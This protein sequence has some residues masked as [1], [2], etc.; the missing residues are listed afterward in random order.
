MMT[1]LIGRLFLT[2]L[3]A[4]LTTS[5]MAQSGKIAGKVT[6]QE[7]GDALIG[8]SVLVIGTSL[9]AATDFDGNYNIL[10]VPPGVYTIR[11]SYVGYTNKTISNVRV[12]TGLT[13]R[14]DVPLS[15]EVLTLGEEITITAERPMVQKDQTASTATVSGDQIAAL[16]VTEISQVVSLQ[17]GNVGGHFR[18]GRTGEVAYMIDGVPVTDKYDG[19]AVVDVNKNMVSELQVISGAFNAEYG[20]AMSAIVN[21][22]TKDGTNKIEGSLGTYFGD[23]LTSHDDIFPK[24][25]TY[26]P[27][28]IQNYEGSLSGALIKD[29]L[30]F[31]LVGRY[32]N[33]GG[34]FYGKRKYNADNFLYEDPITLKTVASSPGD[35]EYVQMNN[36]S[37]I[38]G[39]GKF[40]WPIS[41]SLKTSVNLIYEKREWKDYNRYYVYNPDG[42]KTNYQ[43]SYTALASLTHTVSAS[44]FYTVSVSGFSKFFENYVNDGLSKNYVHPSLSNS[45]ASYTFAAGGMDMNQFQRETQS[46]AAK[47]DLWSQVTNEHQIK[48]GADIKFHN[49]DFLSRNILPQVAE[50]TFIPAAGANPYINPR[51][52]DITTNNYDK[53]NRTPLEMAAYIQ[54]K[55]EFTNFILNVGLRF[56][57]FDPAGKSPADPTDP[58]IYTPMKESNRF[59]DS[60]GN[61]KIDPSEQDPINNLK[62]LAEREKYWWKKSKTKYQI[63]PRIGAAFPITDRGKIYFS[64]GHF[65]QFPNFD[66]LYRNANYKITQGSGNVGTVGNADLKPEKNVQMEL[67]LNQQLTDNFAVDATVYFRDFRDLS[68]TRSDEII[69]AIGNSYNQVVNSDFAFIRGFI[70]TLNQR[71]SEGLAVTLDY[72]F[73][74]AKGTASDPDAARNAILGGQQPEVK[75]VSLDWDQTHT[76]NTT[77]NYSQKN[78]GLSTIVTFGSGNPYTP[79]T[80]ADVASLALNSQVRPSTI[81]MDLR[82]YYNIDI[83]TGSLSLYARI[84]NLFDTLNEYGVFNDS[85]RAGYTTDELYARKNGADQNLKGIN[86]LDEYFTNPQ[87][88]SEPRRIEFGVSY[89]F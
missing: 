82:G 69:T 41:T 18:G 25:S 88:Y 83:P 65:Y 14:I 11:V 12:A 87:F 17:A 62:S 37:R 32:V 77:V 75:L 26:N 70:L 79:R 63:S 2:A 29:N 51:Y 85:G 57:W 28:N 34:H 84:Y 54:D 7:N 21:V 86:T 31:F 8:A 56:D 23:Y 47:I 42:I 19:S 72:T 76:V 39:Q 55:I 35:N 44:T 10:N 20:Q 15:A 22:S 33:F 27:L 38:S 59:N 4:M 71:M 1:K 81:N 3:F 61:G 13:A 5:V 73:Q 49:I 64:Y 67:G 68:G 53:Y 40:T 46:Y 58:N 52:G 43:D 24:P 66:L 9:G 80:N 6:D 60:N 74:I 50:E 16:P 30:Y 45:Y 48:A 89:N 78:W 36:S